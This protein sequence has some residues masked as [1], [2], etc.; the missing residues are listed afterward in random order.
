[1]DECLICDAWETLPMPRC[2]PP[3]ADEAEE[4]SD[5]GVPSLSVP[6]PARERRSGR[7]HSAS[8][9]RR[10][11][12]RDGASDADKASYARYLARQPRWVRE[13]EASDSAVAGAA[14]AA[15]DDISPTFGCADGSCTSCKA[16]GRI[17]VMRDCLEEQRLASLQRQRLAAAAPPPAAASKKTPQQLRALNDAY[18]KSYETPTASA[19]AAII[20]STGLTA[21]DIRIWFSS[22]RARDNKKRKAAGEGPRPRAGASRRPRKQ[23]ATRAAPLG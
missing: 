6:D 15:S 10:G 13:F 21:Q 22:K 19:L 1:M 12:S 5:A 23:L 2:V 8:S 3:E 9:M 4:V 14:A 16:W 7:A 17:A 20:S 18:G 11:A